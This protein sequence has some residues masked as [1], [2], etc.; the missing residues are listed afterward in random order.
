M[1]QPA[2]VADILAGRVAAGTTATINGWIRTRR[3][4]KAGLSFLAVH[5]GSCFDAL[6]VVAPANAEIV[7]RGGPG[8]EAWGHPLE[9]TAQY[10]HIT[11]GRTKPPVCPWRIEVGDPGPEARMLFLHVFE[12]TDEA[13]REATP[14]RFV[15]PAG[16]DIGD[17]WQ[18]RFNA[19][20]PLGGSVGVTNLTST[21]NTAA[22][23]EWTGE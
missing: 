14:V 16:V 15:A 19:N 9:K 8:Q 3:D 1:P 18:V 6:Q 20:G 13:V 17:R 10:N 22:Q 7:V 11:P 4:S 5:D 2:R 12:I 23:Y 21:I